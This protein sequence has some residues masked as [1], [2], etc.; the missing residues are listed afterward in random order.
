MQLQ[1]MKHLTALVMQLQLQ[2]LLLV[3]VPAAGLLL[4][5]VCVAEQLAPLP[6]LLWWLQ[7][8]R[9]EGQQAGQL[10]EQPAL[11][12]AHLA[13][14]SAAALHPAL[15]LAKNCADNDVLVFDCAPGA[16]E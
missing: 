11:Q 15:H 3:T 13:V 2:L 4:Q 10:T 12:A 7:Q 14:A 1:L 6:L 8:L 5:Q 9:A 16:S